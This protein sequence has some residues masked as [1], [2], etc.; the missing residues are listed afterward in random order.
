MD[1]ARQGR[2]QARFRR[3][4]GI[5]MRHNR[6]SLPAILAAMVALLAILRL[7]PPADG[8]LYPVCMFHT[9]TGLLC[10]IC[11]GTRALAA[12]SA[13]RGLEAFRSNPLIAIGAPLL[14]A[15]LL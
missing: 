1:R 6:L 12:L 8:T 5:L 13:G 9:W 2:P 11:G 10:P 14:G 7:F 3:Q 4:S 15:R